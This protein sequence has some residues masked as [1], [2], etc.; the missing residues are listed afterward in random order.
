MS[1]TGSA[2][3]FYGRGSYTAC[4]NTGTTTG[5]GATKPGALA[6]A[7]LSEGGFVVACK[8]LLDCSK[9]FGLEL[10]DN[11]SRRRI[12]AKDADKFIEV[13][14]WDTVAETVTAVPLKRNSLAGRL[15]CSERELG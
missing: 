10:M 1:V 12:F 6:V 9:V 8:L 14:G 7:A 3:H 2:M 11:G 15:R 4:G 13:G 5:A